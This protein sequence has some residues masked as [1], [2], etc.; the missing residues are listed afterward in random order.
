MS[1]RFCDRVWC[2]VALQKLKKV[3]N[4]PN[5]APILR[6]TTAF[7]RNRK[8]HISEEIGWHILRWNTTCVKEYP[9][10]VIF[11]QSNKSFVQ[12]QSAFIVQPNLC[13]QPTLRQLKLV[14][15]W[16]WERSSQP[17]DEDEEVEELRF[18]RNAITW[19]FSPNLDE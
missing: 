11:R 10:S 12:L 17:C 15:L 9:C 2:M 7:H 4:F 3:S 19:F 5:S 14:Q 6:Q 16:V 1:C 18:P 13:G 8:C